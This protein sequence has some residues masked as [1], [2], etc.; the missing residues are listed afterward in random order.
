MLKPLFRSRRA[1]ALVTLTAALLALS[2]VALASG[3]KTVQVKDNYFT[4]KKL[5]VSKGTRVTWKWDAFLRHNVAVRSG[6]SKFKS[7]TQVRGSFSHT[8]TKA[9]TYHLFCTLHTYMKMT[10]VV[11]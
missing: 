4:V 1:L 8:F 3:S 6:P 7:R 9:G 10:I 11:R 2:S 5:T